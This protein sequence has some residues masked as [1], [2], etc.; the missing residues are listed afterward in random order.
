MTTE[1]R[2]SAMSIGNNDYLDLIERG[3]GNWLLRTRAE[4]LT[5]WVGSY[6]PGTATIKRI[7]QEFEL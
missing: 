3:D 4:Y 7:I 6:K 1:R 5:L 2:H